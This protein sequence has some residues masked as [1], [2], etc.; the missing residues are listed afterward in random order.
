VP[1][2]RR[3]V[4]SGVEATVA[5]C[6]PRIEGAE[7]RLPRRWV[8][9][10]GNLVEFESVPAMPSPDI[11]GNVRAGALDMSPMRRQGSLLTE[12]PHAPN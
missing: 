1:A 6:F 11:R 12:R 10:W 8:A 4:A 2:G 7:A 3:H 5:R 9:F